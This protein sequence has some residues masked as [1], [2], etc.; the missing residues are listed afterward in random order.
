[1]QEAEHTWQFDIFGFTEQTRSG[2]TLAML[3]FH[4]V[5]RAGFTTDYRLD[6]TKLCRILRT[7]EAGYQAEN[8]YHNR[9]CH[10]IIG[11][12]SVSIHISLQQVTDTPIVP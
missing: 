3:T 1:M 5:R 10:V 2:N 8:P 4:L 12:Q 11:A 6:E 9:C 7:L